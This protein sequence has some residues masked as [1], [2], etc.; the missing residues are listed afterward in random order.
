[1]IDDIDRRIVDILVDDARISLKDLAARVQLSAP[2]VSDR[3]RRLEDRGVIR[4]FTVD[5]DPR[6]LGYMLQAIVRIRPLPGQLHVV[7]KL[8]Q[9]IPAFTECDKVTGD[10]CFIARLHLRAIDELDPILERIVEKAETNTAIVKMQPI[11]R[12]LPPL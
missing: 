7:E 6:A 9:D 12:R 8:I 10:D 4:A 11:R 3:L 2:S 5:I 1:M